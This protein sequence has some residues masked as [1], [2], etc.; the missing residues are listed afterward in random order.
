[1]VTCPVAAGN[2]A[3]HMAGFTPAAYPEV[4]A[5]TAMSDSDGL[6]GGNGG[7]AGPCNGLTPTQI[8]QKIR[9]DAQ[10]HATSA[11]GF[12]GD[13]LHPVSGKYFGYLAWAG[14]Y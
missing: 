11:N 13:P 10:A 6:S 14:G 3:A 5:V 2:S 9:T 12:T 1:M 8:I 4:L 7:T